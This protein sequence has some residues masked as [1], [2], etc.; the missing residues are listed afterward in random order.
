MAGYIN[1]HGK[2]A[3]PPAYESAEHFREGIAAVRVGG[4]WGYIDSTGK[5]VIRPQFSIAKDFHEG[6][7]LVRDNQGRNKFIDKKGNV[8]VDVSAINGR[9]G[10][11]FSD[12]LLT[13]AYGSG[14]DAK[15]G[16]INKHGIAIEPIYRAVRSFSEGLAAVGTSNGYGFIDTTGAMIIPPRFEDCKPFSE[17][18]AAVLIK[19][20]LIGV[21]GNRS[22]SLWGF[23]DRAGKMVIPASFPQVESFSDGLAIVKR[24]RLHGAIDRSG[25]LVVPMIYKQMSSYSDGRAAVLLDGWTGIH[26]TDWMGD[27]GYVNNVGSLVISGNTIGGSGDHV[28]DEATPFSEGVAFV[29]L[30]STRIGRVDSFSPERPIRSFRTLCIDTKGKVLW[31]VKA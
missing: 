5:Y 10:D 20:E 26:G 24:G 21:A 14:Y 30:K 1:L 29:R 19:G 18:Y 7:A 17:G 22:P 3:I 8:A 28:L 25:T 31:E 23:V 16:Y 15:C 9:F 11:K 12:G 27:C 6:L 13:A 2:W 4:L